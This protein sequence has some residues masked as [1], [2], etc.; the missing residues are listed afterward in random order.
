MDI[1]TYSTCSTNNFMKTFLYSTKNE[2]IHRS[3]AVNLLEKRII[4]LLPNTI[5]IE[6][7]IKEGKN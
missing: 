5:G 2:S 6:L 4:N 1:I 7:E 3:Y